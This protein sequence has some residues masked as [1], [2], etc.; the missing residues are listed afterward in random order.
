MSKC[1]VAPFTPTS[2][3]FSASAS[4]TSSW[5]STTIASRWMRAARAGASS[6]ALAEARG[7]AREAAMSQ[8]LIPPLYIGTRAD[9]NF[10]AQTWE[11]SDHPLSQGG[12]ATF[13]QKGLDWRPACG[14]GCVHVVR[15]GPPGDAWPRGRCVTESV[16]QVHR[17]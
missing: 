9:L 10:P 15:A 12:S 2:A 1:L 7:R 14:L 4:G 11:P 13:N 8:D 3:H 6:A 16:K 17:T 5:V